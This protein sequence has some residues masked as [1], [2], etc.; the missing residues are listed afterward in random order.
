MKPYNENWERWIKQ[1]IAKHFANGVTVDAFTKYF[2]EG[3]ERATE[4][5]PHYIE[6]RI[7]GPYVRENAKDQWRLYTE[8]NVLCVAQEQNEDAWILNRITGRVSRL[9]TN[10]II[11]RRYGTGPEDD[12]GEIGFLTL[13][14]KAADRIQVSHFGKIRPDTRIVQASVEGHYHIYFD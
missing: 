14:P 4:D 9:F 10:N 7:D 6:I 3:F 8:V 1:S 11:V 13:V 12:Q 2:I 5:E